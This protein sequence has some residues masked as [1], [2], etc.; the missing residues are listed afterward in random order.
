MS[1]HELK[2]AQFLP[3]KVMLFAKNHVLCVESIPLICQQ[4]QR[5]ILQVIGRGMESSGRKNLKK[6]KSN[7]V[8]VLELNFQHAVLPLCTFK[9]ALTNVCAF[10]YVPA[11]KNC[12][13]IK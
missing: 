12:M 4:I 8:A 2:T 7:D 3:S 6:T 5:E 10:K 11:H 1:H 9:P 13:C